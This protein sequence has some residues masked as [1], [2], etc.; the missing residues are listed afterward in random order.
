MCGMFIFLVKLV[1][2][3]WVIN[4]IAY[5]YLLLCINVKFNLLNCSLYTHSKITFYPPGILSEQSYSALG[6][7]QSLVINVM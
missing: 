3:V 7:P 1:P 5:I 2:D 6:K 4:L